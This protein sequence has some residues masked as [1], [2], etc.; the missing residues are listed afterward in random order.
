MEILPFANHVSEGILFIQASAHQLYQNASGTC[1]RCAG[2]PDTTK[3]PITL[4]WAQITPAGGTHTHTHGSPWHL[5]FFG[6]S[7]GW[8]GQRKSH[9]RMKRLR[10]ERDAGEHRHRCPGGWW[11]RHFWRVPKV[12]WMRAWKT[13]SLS[14]ALSVSMTPPVACRQ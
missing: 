7:H 4:A 8:Q 6:Q 13:P 9:L 2:A 10:G 1:A 11:I 12:G 14:K 3:F 5:F